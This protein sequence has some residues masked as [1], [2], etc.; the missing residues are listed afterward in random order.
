MQN[1][2]LSQSSSQLKSKNWRAARELSDAVNAFISNVS[3]TY[4]LE[5]VRRWGIL[6]IYL[7]VLGGDGGEIKS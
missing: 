3:G 1:Q 5:D 4:T 2:L 7:F 6:F